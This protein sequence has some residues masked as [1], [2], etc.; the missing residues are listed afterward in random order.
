VVFGVIGPEVDCIQ[1]RFWNPSFPVLP[2]AIHANVQSTAT[3]AEPGTVQA[4][5]QLH[6]GSDAKRAA[7]NV[8]EWRKRL[9]STPPEDGCGRAAAAGKQRRA[10]SLSSMRRFPFGV[11]RICPH[12]IGPV[13]RHYC[14]QA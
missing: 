8:W 5:V 2:E 12:L 9:A 13:H 14:V 3:D 6:A 10:A 4:E 1:A 7:E 11:N